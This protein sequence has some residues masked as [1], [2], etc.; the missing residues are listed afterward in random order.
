MND[1][2]LLVD[3]AEGSLGVYTNLCTEIIRKKKV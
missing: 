2:L 1:E 3:V